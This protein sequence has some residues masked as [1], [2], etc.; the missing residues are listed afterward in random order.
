MVYPD[1]CQ[2]EEIREGCPEVVTLAVSCRMHR[3]LQSGETDRTEA[4]AFVHSPIHSLLSKH[5]AELPG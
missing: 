1:L 4:Y 5:F 2:P 3:S